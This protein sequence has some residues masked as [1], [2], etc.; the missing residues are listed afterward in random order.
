[1]GSKAPFPPF[2]KKKG[3]K[4]ILKTTSPA[5]LQERL[6]IGAILKYSRPTRENGIRPAAFLPQSIQVPMSPA[7]GRPP[8]DLG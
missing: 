1:M 6:A 5:D 2:A 3:G 4:R 8:A 7:G